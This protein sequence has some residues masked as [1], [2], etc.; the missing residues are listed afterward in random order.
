MALIFGTHRKSVP[1]NYLLRIYK[2][3][4]YPA[5]YVSGRYAPASRSNDL[6]PC[7][8]STARFFAYAKTMSHFVYIR[9]GR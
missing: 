3:I 6:Q 5:D 2:F 9:Q 1:S 8:G 4:F 7:K